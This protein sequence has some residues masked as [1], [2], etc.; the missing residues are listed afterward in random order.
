MA[1]TNNAVNYITARLDEITELKKPQNPVAYQLGFLQGFLAQHI[2][3]DP[4]LRSQ[5]EKTLD[6]VK[7]TVLHPHNN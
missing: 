7:E 6:N 3:E 2:K 5:L 4:W 1:T